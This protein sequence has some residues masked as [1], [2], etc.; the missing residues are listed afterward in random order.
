[1]NSIIKNFIQAPVIKMERLD[2]FFIELSKKACNMKCKH[3]YIPKNSFTME[4][5]FLEIKKIKT[6]LKQIKD[7]NVK[8]L[9]EN[10]GKL[11]DIGLGNYFL[12]MIS[13]A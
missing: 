1:M 11:H 6:A 3:C 4:K 12:D 8:H 13:E 10:R 2:N 5:D 7:L 9:E